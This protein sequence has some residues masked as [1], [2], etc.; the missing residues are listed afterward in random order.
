[1]TPLLFELFARISL[2]NGILSTVVPQHLL[3]FT[4]SIVDGDDDDDDS[5]IVLLPVEE[6]YSSVFLESNSVYLNIFSAI[7]SYLRCFFN[8]QLSSV[9][10]L[11]LSDI[12]LHLK[13]FVRL[14]KFG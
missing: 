2:M 13:P 9:F 8:F 7:I 1:M 10:A 5:V 11:K 6:T 4:A 14:F 12:C 3:F